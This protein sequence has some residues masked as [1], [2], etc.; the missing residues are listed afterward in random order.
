MAKITKKAASKK[1]AVSR[2]VVSKESII[3]NFD[4]IDN[5]YSERFSPIEKTDFLITDVYQEGDSDYSFEREITLLIVEPIPENYEPTNQYEVVKRIFR[6][7]FD[8]YEGFSPSGSQ[9]WDSDLGS[10]GEPFWVDYVE[11]ES[12]LDVNILDEAS[13]KWLANHK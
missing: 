7:T 4:L 13:L 9:F 12:G 5:P 3:P 10:A 11:E 8:R 2:K 6:L 1:K